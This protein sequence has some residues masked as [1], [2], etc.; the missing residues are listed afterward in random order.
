MAE[1]LRHVA[2]LRPWLARAGFQFLFVGVWGWQVF[3]VFSGGWQAF[4]VFCGGWQVFRA[5]SGGWQVFSFFSWGG[6]KQNAGQCFVC[7]AI[8]RAA[9]LE[10]PIL[11][12][13]TPS[14]GLGT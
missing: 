9:K 2:Q 5:F 11:I 4:R 3:R 7:T 14:K 13:V 1:E 8:A 6:C 12:W 10:K